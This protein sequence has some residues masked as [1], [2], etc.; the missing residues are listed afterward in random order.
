[1][2]VA[3]KL[4]N[5]KQGSIIHR[6][7]FAEHTRISQQ[8]FSVCLFVFF[9]L[10]IVVIHLLDFA[11]CGR[12]YAA[13]GISVVQ[14]I[15]SLIS[16]FLFKYHLAIHKKRILAAAYVNIFRVII[17]LELQYFLYDEYISYTIIICIILCTSLSIIGHIGKYAAILAASLSIDVMITIM[18]NYEFLHSHEMKMYIIDNLF[19]LII[20]IGINFS[21]S[22]LKYRDFE[23]NKQILYLSERDSLTGLLN[24]KSLECLVEKHIGGNGLCAM[25]LLDLDN[26]KA[27]ND[28]LGHY[29]G[30]DCLRATADELK[31]VF[32][33]T[34]YVSRLGGDEFTV[35][36]PDIQS[37]DFVTDRANMLLKTI[38]RSYA[39][40]A[41]KIDVTCSVGIAFLRMNQD[42]LYENLYK[43]ADSA[44]YTSKANGKNM[45]TIFS[46]EFSEG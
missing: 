37:I 31:K 17:I 21:I 36:L 40:E 4:K 14:M 27:V 9:V 44:M 19:V 16:Y 6:E 38:P 13:L 18:K 15:L 12:L 2:A 24:R 10:H 5:A 29:E 28:T 43:A 32:R 46:N 42:N 7:D 1:M 30:D 39:H 8:I 20:A 34:D 25:I 35:F 33:S 45:V 23:K 22:Y 3:Q 41:G 26:F 11:K